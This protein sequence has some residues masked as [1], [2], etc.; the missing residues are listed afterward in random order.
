[1]CGVVGMQRQ[2]IVIFFGW[3][4]LVLLVWLVLVRLVLRNHYN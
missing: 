1:M 2:R 4:R 3:M